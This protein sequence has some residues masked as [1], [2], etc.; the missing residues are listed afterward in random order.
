M[1]AKHGLNLVKHAHS[2]VSNTLN[3]SVAIVVNI[4]GKHGRLNRCECLYTV[5]TCFQIWETDIVQT[6][7]WESLCFKATPFCQ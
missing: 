4:W 2:R 7:D 5:V 1:A 3:I 6:W